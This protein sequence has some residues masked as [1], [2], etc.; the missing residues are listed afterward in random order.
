LRMMIRLRWCLAIALLLV[1]VVSGYGSELA[2]NTATALIENEL[3]KQNIV[4]LTAVVVV[5]GKV[6]YSRGF[7]SADVENGATITKSSVMRTGSLAKPITAAAAMK[8]YEEGKLDL[9]A[10]VQKY[11]PS[12]PDKK[13]PVTTR[14]LLGHLGGV[15]HYKPDYS[16]FISTKHYAKLTDSFEQFAAEP[17]VAEPGTK[18]VYSSNGYTVVGCVIE[19]ASGKSIG[20]ALEKLVFKP[21]GMIATQLDDN[22]EII[23]GRSRTYTRTR[24]GTIANAPYVD[25]SNKITSGGL[26]SS[27]EDLARFVIALQS[28]RLLIE[29]SLKLMWTTQNTRDGKPTNY[30]LG[31]DVR[32]ENG[33]R[34]IEHGGSAI[35]ATNSIYITP[36]Q[37][38]SAVVVTNTDGVNAKAIAQGLAAIYAPLKTVEVH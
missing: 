14:E 25:T 21:T 26:L 35:G 27:A 8:L 2:S 10:P 15:R 1:L 9:D 17:L 31:W 28:K 5:D 6:A 33:R 19:G 7:G 34:I 13:W 36:E 24:K 22:A 12:F 4:G 29:S 37:G 16:D 18:Y 3:K 30:G 23:P 20:A 38:V 11:C 32:D